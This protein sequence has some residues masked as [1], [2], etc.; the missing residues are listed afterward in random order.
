M[1]SLKVCI[2]LLL[3]SIAIAQ[4]QP[5]PPAQT[6]EIA[7]WKH[8]MIISANITQISF[9]DWAQGGEN[10]LAYAL[11]LEGKSAYTEGVIDWVNS[12]KFGFGQAKLGSQG[13]RKTDDKIDLESVLTYKIG[14]YVNPYASATLKTQFTEGVTYDATGLATAVSNFFDPAYLTQSAGVGYQP[15]PEVKTRFGVAL[16][17]IVSNKFNALYTDD[18][19]TTEIEKLKVDGGMESVTEVGMTVM[20]NVVL[21]AKLEL[22]API[23]NLDQTTVRSDNTLSAKVNKYL[24]VNFNIQLIND[25]RVQARTQIKQTLAVGFNYTLM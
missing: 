16:R 3:A 4:V 17:E 15:L 9:T 14:A 7:P 8:N 22:F 23:K 20:E 21:T 5:P 18:P 12:Y 24:S 6:A 11:F 25:S 19:S 1:R 13:I 10:A 2:L